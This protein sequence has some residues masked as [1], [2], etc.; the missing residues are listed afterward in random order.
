MRW[1]WLLSGD[2]AAVICYNPA[3]WTVL[4][5]YTGK[6]ESKQERTDLNNCIGYISVLISYHVSSVETGIRMKYEY[7]ISDS[8]VLNLEVTG[9]TVGRPVDD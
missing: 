4:I 3:N 5:L 9:I 7:G 2:P 1:E 8:L 6:I